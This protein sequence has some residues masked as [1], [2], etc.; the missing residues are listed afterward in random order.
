VAEK[1]HDARASRLSPER[2][3]L[4]VESFDVVWTAVRDRHWDPDLAGV[5]WQA[6]RDE[7]RPQVG[8]A[9]TMP[10]ARA[11]IQ[12]A[13]DRLGQSHFDIIPSDVYEE[14]GESHESGDGEIGLTVRV[15]DGRALVTAVRPNSPAAR[16]GL[17]PGWELVSIDETVLAPMM[18]RMSTAYADST[19]QQVTLVSALRARL[20]GP[21]GDAVTLEVLDGQAKPR[22]L[23][24]VREEAD[25]RR[26]H[27]GHLPPMHLRYESR[28]LEGDIG[29]IA[30]NVFLAPDVVMARIED[31]IRS[32]MDS[33]GI[34]LDL[35]GNPGGIGAMSMG[36]AG[37]F[38][39]DAG[40][41]L[42]TMQTRDTSL[43]FAVFPRAKTYAG[44]L[45]ILV[46]GCTASTAEI[47][48][49]GLQDLGRA[50]IFGTRTAGAALPATM[51]RLPNGDGFLH[52]IADY[53]SVGG[54]RLEG[55]GVR[56]DVEV[57]PSRPA[58]LSGSDPVLAA[59]AEW[60]ESQ[61]RD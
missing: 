58:L 6:V 59:A 54:Q 26:V 52:A 29:Y 23:D 15:V 16:E 46:D 38:V 60:I 44:P 8:E 9:E 47:L 1:T 61:A 28:R 30:F 20:N 11:L 12:S 39:D 10:K 24:V 51:E 45:A 43:R 33:N 31:A 34:I 53:V 36:I 5:D 27:F 42:G 37:W 25:G 13:L 2:I 19:L 41:T 22:T 48:A 49:G 4:N 17:E 3:E 7:I 50:K 32:F 18:E 21:V 55:A 35:R 14:I 56:P 57:E 40:R